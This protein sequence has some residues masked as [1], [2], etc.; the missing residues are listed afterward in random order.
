[1]NRNLFRRVSLALVTAS[2]LGTAKAGC[3]IDVSDYVGWQIIFAGTVTGHIDEDGREVDEFEGCDY[4]RVL[5]IDYTMAIE[6]AEYSYSYAYHP[7][8]VILSDGNSFVACIDDEVFDVQVR[9]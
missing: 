6:C 7:D 3:V 4:G 1:M 2:F 5:I 9:V 8:I